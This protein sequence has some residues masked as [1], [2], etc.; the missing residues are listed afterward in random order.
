MVSLMEECRPVAG[1]VDGD[2]GHGLPGGL[3][4]LLASGA[5][6]W[7]RGASAVVTLWRVQGAHR[8]H[9]GACVC[10]PWRVWPRRF[11]PVALRLFVEAGSGRAQESER[12]LMDMAGLAGVE[13]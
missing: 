13:G 9:T 8:A 3:A 5:G 6:K 7:R 1:R 12:E 2:D 10:T 4:R 11:L